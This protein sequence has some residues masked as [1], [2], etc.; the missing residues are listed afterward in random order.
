MKLAISGKGGVGKTIL[1]SLLAREAVQAGFKVLVVDADPDANLASQL[2]FKER[3]IT[4]LIEFKDLINDRT[5]GGRLLKLNPKVDDI[6][7]RFCLQKDGI[8]L[9]EMGTIRYGGNGC[10]CPENYFLKA[11]LDHILLARDELVLV[12]M[13]AGIE[14]LGRGTAQA[15]DALIVVVNPDKKSL[16]TKKRITDLAAHLGIQNLY[17]IANKIRDS[18][19][20]DMI[21]TELPN[22]PLGLIGYQDE[23]RKASRDGSPVNAKNI[24]NEMTDIFDKLSRCLSP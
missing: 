22:P 21:L 13:E 9:L 11:L 2:G 12:D 19:D 3:E 4:P 14:H 6:P 23:V 10:T 24:E 7:D 16:E 5:G 20:K 8:K 1:T 18:A 15:V 17:V